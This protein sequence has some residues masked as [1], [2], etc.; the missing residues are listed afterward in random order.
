[1][2]ERGIGVELAAYIV[3]AVLLLA[4][5]Y[6]LVV[7]VTQQSELARVVGFILS[8]VA[9]FVLGKWGYPRP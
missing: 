1:M 9:L 3:V 4:A 2:T 6:L 7:H 8:L 5:G